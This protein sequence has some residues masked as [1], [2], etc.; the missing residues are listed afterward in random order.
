MLRIKHPL[1]LCLSLVIFLLPLQAWSIGLLIPTSNK[2]RPF[3]IESHRATVEITNTAALTTVVQ[4]FKN[5]TNR[6]IEAQFVFPIP[7]GGTLSNFSLWMNGK[8]TKGAILEKDEARKIYESI[9]RRMQ[10]PGLVEY[11][12]AKL[13]RTSIFPIPAGGTQ[14]LEIQFGQVLEKQGDMYR[15]VYPLSAGADYIVAKTEKDFTL[16]GTI[17]SAIPI[18]NIYS[19]SH[20]IGVSRKKDTKVVFGAESL[21]QKLDHDFELFISFSKKDIGISLMTHDPDGDAGEDGYFM[22]AIAPKV[23]SS[24]HAEIGQTLSFV[25][26]TSGS[27]AGQKMVQARKT[28]SYCI[29]KLR[30]QDHFNIIRFSTDVETLHTA[31][32]LATPKNKA[33][34]LAF[35]KSLRA[36]G[37]TAISSALQIALNQK[38]EKYQ[39][40][41]ILFITDG[42][43][44][45]GNTDVRTI[46]SAVRKDAKS[47]ARIFSFGIGFNVN[48]ILLDAIASATRGRPDYIKPNE[49][50]QHAI[51]ALYTR[52]SAPVMTDI[53]LDFGGTKVYDM[54]PKPIPDL[55][56]GDQIVLFGRNKKNFSSPIRI[57]G[58]IGKALKTFSFGSKGSGKRVVLDASSS[59]PLE[60]IPKLWATRKV[61]FLLDSIR[62]NG[63][64]K[65]LKEEVIRLGKKFG[66]VTPYTSYLAVDDSEFTSNRS[67]SERALEDKRE[68][69]G[70]GKK[71]E[72]NKLRGARDRAPARQYDEAETFDGF[73]ADSGEEAVAA[74]KK[75][76]AFKESQTL[77]NERM[78]KRRYI[79]SRTFYYE[80]GFWRQ[81]DI[82][83]G[84]SVKVKT[85]TKAFFRLLK[86]YP[87]LKKV[88][89]RLGPNIV[90]KIG[91]VVYTFKK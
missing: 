69:R 57:R 67:V 84:K 12:D 70:S 35:V 38:T 72:I 65:E 91:G 78:L 29:S 71:G 64:A 2:I 56:R 83:S 77:K 31:P 16:T 42:Q 6:P 36:A 7:E 34:A 18:K 30:P 20:T 82:K 88:T 37:G 75:T 32:V 13:F 48:T 59:A 46:L 51:A 90:I 79:A 80:K 15:Y 39:P 52:I 63:E 21:Q 24:A 43:P 49:D 55:F 86:K 66:L 58:R 19:P 61:G 44:T 54:Y 76:L 74:S 47:N 23:E 68:P 17:H 41:E 9:V 10:D 11:M 26:D 50:I 5:H 25:M 14:K 87:L 73:N 53:T 85:Y 22:V 89:S 81:A 1:L 40:H 60:F 28:L 3:D 45:V 62:V 33:A 27:M 4:V 8:K